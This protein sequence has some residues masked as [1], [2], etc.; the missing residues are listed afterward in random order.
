MYVDAQILTDINCIIYTALLQLHSH[1]TSTDIE[2]DTIRIANISRMIVDS[3]HD[4]DR[5][6]NETETIIFGRTSLFNINDSCAKVIQILSIKCMNR[7]NTGRLIAIQIV[8]QSVDPMRHCW[9]LRYRKGCRGNYFLI[10]CTYTVT[11]S[12]W[13]LSTKINSSITSALRSSIIR[14]NAQRTSIAPAAMDIAIM[15]IMHCGVLLT[16]RFN[17]IYRPIMP[18][19][20]F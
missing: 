7:T 5:I 14:R 10:W 3:K 19:V 9:Q 8:L 20:S 16:N 13:L 17:D 1:S 4:I 2:E 12:A 6:F 11:A 18:M 15:W